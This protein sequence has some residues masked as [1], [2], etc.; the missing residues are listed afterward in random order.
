VSAT[1]EM[2][3][4]DA[5]FLYSET[6]TAHMHTLKIAEIDVS[7]RKAP[8]TPERLLDLLEVWLDRLPSL[9]LR[10]VTVPH[11]LG[12]PVWVE[13]PDLDLSRHVQ[14]RRARPPGGDRELAS[15]VAEV[16]GIPLNRD[17]PLWE[18]TVVEGLREG[19]VAFVVKLHHCLADGAAAVAMLENA[20][21]IDDRDAFV[22]PARPEPLPSPRS[23]Y[24]QAV[25][26]G[27]RRLRE[28]PDFVRRTG[29]GLAAARRVRRQIDTSLP[30]PF[31]SPRTSLNVSLDAERTFAM[32]A[33]PLSGLLQAKRLAGVTLN[34][35]FLTVCGGALR[36]YLARRDELPTSSLVAAVPTA[37]HAGERRFRGNHVDNLMLPL[38]TELGDVATRAQT[39]HQ[40]VRAARQIRA[41]LGTDLFEYRAGLTS[42]HLYPLG[43]RLWAR[44]RLADHTRPPV[45][46]VASNVAGPRQPLALADAAVTALYSVGPILEGIGLNITAWSYVDHLYVSTLG[47]PTSLPDPWALIDDLHDACEELI[48]A[49]T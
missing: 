35:V 49:Y 8:L 47:C 39:I 7:G 33:L 38:G 27:G 19:R 4:L 1:E 11:R 2:T 31:S 26:N 34:D 16:A 48:D 36:R 20:F 44:T 29:T 9:R 32:T 17:R 28:L 23:L 21:V 25:R 30:L 22:Q 6:A 18:L 24:R 5:R 42:P 45:N 15:I 41:A 40:A 46:L 10:V 37:T 3:G 14:W 43:I 13:D 12:H